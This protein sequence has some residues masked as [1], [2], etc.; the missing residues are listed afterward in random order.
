MPIRSQGVFRQYGDE[1]LEAL[2]QICRLKNTDIPGKN[3]IH[4]F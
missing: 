2:G 1:D 3:S 4:L